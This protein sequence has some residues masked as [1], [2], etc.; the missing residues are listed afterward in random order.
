M[1]Q[2]QRL[3]LA[4]IAAASSALLFYH[5]RKTS[6]GIDNYS[7]DNFP[8]STGNSPFNIG[9][10][11]DMAKP[12]GIRNNNPGNIEETGT[13]WRGRVAD[14][15]RFII[16]DKPENGIRAISRILDTY[17]NK[18]GINTLERIINRWAPPVE[19]DTESYIQHAEKVLKVSRH[20]PIGF[21]HRLDLIKVIIKH[22]N[23]V[24]P[25]SDQV[26]YD[27]IAAA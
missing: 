11:L 24:Q 3:S 16:F 27:G 17:S 9:N 13:P 6:S 18:Y 5:H 20:T 22:E 10:I 4:A 15:G 23:G 21:Q 19:N 2:T 26:I 8:N 1:N 7:L 25:Y 12:K 14:D